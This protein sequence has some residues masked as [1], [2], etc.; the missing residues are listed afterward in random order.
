MKVHAIGGYEEVGK[1]MTAVEV[2]DEVVIIDAGADMDTVIEEDIDFEDL[3]TSR[4]M[5]LGAIPD[6]SKLMD[7]KREDVEAIII[8]HGHLDHCLALPKIAGA[9]D[10]PIY[11]TPYTKQIVERVIRQDGEWVENEVKMVRMGERKQISENFLLEPVDI[12]HSIPHTALTV[13]HTPEGR[14][15]Y[16]LDF[17]LDDAPTLGDPPDYDRLRELGADGVD[18]Y[19]G[20]STRVDQPGRSRSEAEIA[21]EL[22]HQLDAAFAA[23]QHAIITTF[24]S[25]ITRLNNILKANDKR[26]KV[27]FLGRSLG[28]YTEDAAREGLI[29]PHRFTVK[30]HYDE[31]DEFLHR[32]NPH[33]WLVVCTGHQ[34]EP[35][36]VLTRISRR[37]HPFPL[38]NTR[39]IFSSS[40]IPTPANE[41][42]REGLEDRL[43]SGGAHIE[44]DVHAHGHAMRDEH[45]DII[46]MLNPTHIIPAHGTQEKL[47]SHRDLALNLGYDLDSLHIPRNGKT[48]EI[49]VES[50]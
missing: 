18:V 40:V 46:R 5:T 21:T 45:R 23:G 9:Y 43:R 50:E 48:V 12:T 42:N 11:A 32:F 37:E 39:V 30:S 25:H 14:L 41:A 36:A 7:E 19:I 49:D 8:S 44:R 26:R 10:C 17:K 3:S 15:A 33:R 16:S 27:A 2:D 38:A 4:A 29:N 24:S 28:E 31:I 47:E 1:N 20:E 13:L 6:D 22:E 34:G 35:N